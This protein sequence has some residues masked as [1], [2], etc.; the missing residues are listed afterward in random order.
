MSAATRSLARKRPS[1]RKALL[2]TAMLLVAVA[3]AFPLAWMVLSS[4]KTPAETM[5]GA[6][7]LDPAHADPGSL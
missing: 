7:G 2:A 6:A 4:L 1:G 3:S 5:Q